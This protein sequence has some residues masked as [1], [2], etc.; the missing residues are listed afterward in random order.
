MAR[1]ELNPPNISEEQIRSLHKG[2]IVSLT[3]TIVTGRD[4]AHKYLEDHFIDNDKPATEELAILEELK[5]HL[6]GGILY[7]CGPVVAQDENGEYRFTAA[8]PTTSIRE[9]PYE[10]DVIKLLG[11]RGVIGK[12]GMGP[13]TL[14]AC[15]DLG[16][17]Y[18]H[19]IGGA[20]TYTAKSVKKVH[21]VLK[22]EEFGT[23][24]AFWIIEVENFECVVTMDSHGESLHA[25][26]Q[27]E[28]EKKLQ[29]VF[30]TFS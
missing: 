5:K 14:K 3:G 8:G 25:T 6:G 19:A 16:A 30:A 29:D 22:K 12:G 23:P 7:H 9:E 24:E 10:Y 2:D 21:G 13:K 28:S 15:K 27:T 4:V 1:V 17:V 20:A 26:L 11:M 18:L